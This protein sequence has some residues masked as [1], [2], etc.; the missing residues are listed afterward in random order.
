MFFIAAAIALAFLAAPL[1]GLPYPLG[2]VWKT[3]GIFLLGVYALRRGARL[4]GLALLF[5]SVGD[6]LLEL[7]PQQMVAGMAAFGVAHL[8]YAAAFAGFF[9]RAQTGVAG[10]M[11]AGLVL[12][13]SILLLCW[14]WPEMGV[15]RFPGAGYQAII[16]GM[17]I[18]AMLSRAPALAKAGAALFMLSDTLIAFDLYKGIDPPRGSVWITYATAQILLTWTLSYRR[19]V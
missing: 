7:K 14:F 13:V 10:L 4:A 2:P 1:F 16:T 12:T 6:L 17:V 9:R 18:L 8:F 5:S 11:L 15:L 3:G 19:A